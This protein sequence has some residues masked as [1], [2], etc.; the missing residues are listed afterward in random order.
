MSE[1]LALKRAVDK[2][3][4]PWNELKRILDR[5]CSQDEQED[6]DSVKAEVILESTTK[7]LVS[8]DDIKLAGQHLAEIL[9]RQ[10]DTERQKVA[11]MYV[12]LNKRLPL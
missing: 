10:V 8:L 3:I 12:V 1:V 11:K 7:S 9:D 5:Y 2:K 4:L 6:L